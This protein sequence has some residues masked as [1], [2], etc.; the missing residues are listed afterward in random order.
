MVYAICEKWFDRQDLQDRTEFEKNKQILLIPSKKN[1]VIFGT[2]CVKKSID[3]TILY[4][5]K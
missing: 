4:M 3:L 5:L 1:E 2:Y